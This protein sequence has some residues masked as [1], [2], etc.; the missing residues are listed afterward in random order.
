MGSTAKDFKSFVNP[1]RSIR[2]HGG[3]VVGIYF[4]S[5]RRLRLNSGL[6]TEVAAN[7]VVRAGT[8]ILGRLELDRLVAEEAAGDD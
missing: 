8:R 7:G 1:P 6:L 4:S 2:N 5:T 3:Q